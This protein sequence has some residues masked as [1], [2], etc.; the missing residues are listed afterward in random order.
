M[1][2]K[3]LVSLMLLSVYLL[4]TSCKSAQPFIDAIESARDGLTPT[5]FESNSA[6][7]QALDNG[8]QQAVK[9]L[10]KDGGF[11]RSVYRIPLPKH[12]ASLAEK[13]RSVGLDKPVQEFENSLNNAAE[14]AVPVATGLFKEALEKMTFADVVTIL[15][16]SDTAATEYF[17]RNT[18]VE[19]QR[20][21]LPLVNQA[22][23]KVGVTR[24]YKQLSDRIRPFQKVLGIQIPAGDGIDEYVTQYA[25]QALFAK[26]AT[27]ERLI[28]QNPG[29]RTSELMRKVFSYYQ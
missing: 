2:R 11:S 1:L 4:L 25:T 24:H 14:K 21:F 18:Q 6:L 17:K 20:R 5:Q 15:R 27:E 7:K 10:G 22:T 9:Q 23:S 8:I 12:L 13:A 16:G 28:R 3:P 29:K 19:L 26:I